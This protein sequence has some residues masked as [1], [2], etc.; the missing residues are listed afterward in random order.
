M[1]IVITAT[2]SQLEDSITQ[3]LEA[4]NNSCLA[5]RQRGLTVLLPTQIDFE[6]TINNGSD[7]GLQVKDGEDTTG[8]VDGT[9]STVESTTASAQSTQLTDKTGGDSTS[10]T[11]PSGAGGTSN[12]TITHPNVVTT[13]SGSDTNKEDMTQ[14]WEYK[15]GG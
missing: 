8:S 13:S 12:T 15:Q 4:V 1:P 5:M 6:V 2:P 7:T 9:I 14:Q 10:V 3:A 11:A